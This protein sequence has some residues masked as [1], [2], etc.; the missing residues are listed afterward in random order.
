MTPF[1]VITQEVF[2]PE[3]VHAILAGEPAR[4]R[5]GSAVMVAVGEEPHA[6]PMVKAVPQAT[7]GETLDAPTVTAYVPFVL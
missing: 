3:A 6:P 5:A 2:T 1:P 4:T 7:G